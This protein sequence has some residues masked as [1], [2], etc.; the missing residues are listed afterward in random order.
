MGFKSIFLDVIGDV[1]GLVVQE[2]GV[3]HG[4]LL[5]SGVFGNPHVVWLDA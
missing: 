5:G 3:V 4:N 2:L 1:E